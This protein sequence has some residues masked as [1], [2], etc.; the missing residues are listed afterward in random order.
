M[1]RRVNTKFLAIFTVVVLGLLI[2]GL[3]VRKFIVKESPEGYIARGTQ[4]M[5]DHKYEG[6]IQNFQKAVL[7]DPK[8]PSLWVAYGDALNQLSP[9]DVEYMR[10]AREAWDK[11]LAVQ[12]DNKPA[13]D[14][15]MQ[16]W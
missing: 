9:N 11:A 13:L 16:F 4:L 14:R 5:A 1:A 8:N 3:V 6:A 12:P 2:A 10:R 15:M 7:L